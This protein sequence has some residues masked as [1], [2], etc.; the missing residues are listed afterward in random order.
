MF[1]HTVRIAVY[2][3]LAALAWSHTA[4]AQQIA[5]DRP[6]SYQVRKVASL[7]AVTADWD[8]P[9]WEHAN[10]LDIANFHPLGSDHR[11]KTQARLLHDGDT[12][13][14]MF[15]VEDQYVVARHIAYQSRTHKDSTVEFFFQPTPDSGYFNFEMN[16][17]GTLLLYYITDAT[18]K[19]DGFEHYVEVAK[20]LA[21]A[22]PVHASL[23]KRV[24]PEI[25]EPTTWTVSY[26]IPKA[27]LEAHAGPIP[28][29]HDLHSRGNLYKCADDSSHP[30]WASW[31]P[32]GKKLDFHQPE[33]F[34]PIRFE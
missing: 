22:I 3:A 6:M 5:K 25:T 12:L 33:K 10:T 28:T 24:D 11:P 14:V 2:T 1:L 30:H 29:L 20:A 8:D 32:I 23:P 31:A 18:R 26:R 16:C 19:G 34:A 7:P 4:T 27:L 13:A 15:R 9:V 17:G 21:D